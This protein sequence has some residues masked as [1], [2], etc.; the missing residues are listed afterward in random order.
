MLSAG[1]VPVR[2]VD[3][4]PR[5]LLLR[6]F[7]YWDFPKGQV[8]PGEEPLSAALRELKEET[9]VESVRFPWGMDFKD[10]APYGKGKIA[11]YWIAEVPDVEIILPVSL[12][13]GRP[14]HQ[15]FRWVDY[16]AGRLLVVPRVAE[17][18]EWANA[19]VLSI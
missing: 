7:D 2:Y 18:L 19:I 9:G 15:E 5:F 8:N 13:L 11:R 10:T 17:I 3:R 1:I 6:N 14:E 4:T 16:K 12:E